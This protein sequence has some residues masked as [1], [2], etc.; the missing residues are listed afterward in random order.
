MN[1]QGKGQAMSKAL[2]RFI[3]YRQEIK[4]ARGFFLILARE[5]PC[6]CMTPFKEEAK[7]MYDKTARCRECLEEIPSDKILVCSQ[8]EE[9]VYCSKTCQEKDWKSHKAMCQL[10]NGG[11]ANSK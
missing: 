10:I 9:A 7:L 5:T 11:K 8:C 6:D 4:T 2:Q 1:V 3:R